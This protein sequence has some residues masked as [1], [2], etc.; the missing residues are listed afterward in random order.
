MNTSRRRRPRALHMVKGV[1]RYIRCAAQLRGQGRVDDH[2]ASSAAYC[3]REAVR[4]LHRAHPRPDFL[5]AE[6]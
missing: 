2:M 5:R 1:R 3:A 6:A 4:E